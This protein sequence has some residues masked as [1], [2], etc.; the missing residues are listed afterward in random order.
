MYL[1]KIFTV[2]TPM[3]PVKIFTILIQMYLVKIPINFFFFCS[4]ALKGF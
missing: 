1:V 4:V 2:V 3:Y